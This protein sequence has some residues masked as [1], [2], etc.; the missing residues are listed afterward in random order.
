MTVLVAGTV[1]IDDVK[2]PTITRTGLMG[3]SGA[4]AS[5]AARFF[6][7]SRVVGIIGKDFPREHIE[8]LKKHGVCIDGIEHSDGDSFY[9]SGEYHENMDDRTTH[10]VAV[11]VLEAYDPKLPDHYRDSEVVVLANMSPRNQLDVLGQCDGANFTV[12]DTMDIWIQAERKELLEL[13]GKIDLLVINESEAK[14]FMETTN[15]VKAGRKLLDLGPSNTIVKTGEHGALLFGRGEHDFFRTGAFPLDHVEDP[16]GAG[17]CFLGGLAGHLASTG[18]EKP[19][20]DD[21]KHAIAHGTVVASY[22]CQSFSVEGLV[23]LTGEHISS[24]LAQFRRYT[25]F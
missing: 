15:L 6:A 17:D 12:A 8:T 3:G 24:R 18:R 23:D 11:N 13:L 22:N 9:W 5:M 14:L 20:F 4:Y 16:T 19:Q 1:A 25:Q 10:S 21:L 2:T 7:P